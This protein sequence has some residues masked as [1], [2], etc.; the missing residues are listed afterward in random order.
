[1]RARREQTDDAT[2]R[3]QEAR[4]GAERASDARRKAEADLQRHGQAM[5]GIKGRRP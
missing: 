1:M 4:E 5:S 3:V 2:Q